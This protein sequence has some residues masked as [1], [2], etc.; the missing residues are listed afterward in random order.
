M[1]LKFLCFELN[2][3]LKQVEGDHFAIKNRD[4]ENFTNN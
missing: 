4:L 2:A 3:T 1:W